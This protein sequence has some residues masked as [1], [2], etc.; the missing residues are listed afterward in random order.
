RANRIIA[1]QWRRADIRPHLEK[2]G[3]SPNSINTIPSNQSV[4]LDGVEQGNY[5]KAGVAKPRAYRVGRGLFQLTGDSDSLLAIAPP[6]IAERRSSPY[7]Q[8]LSQTA[9]GR[10]RFEPDVSTAGL[11]TK[12]VR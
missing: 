8:M 3:F 7:W 6:L 9:S 10:G 5:V 2:L 11:P 1:F 12:S 4:T